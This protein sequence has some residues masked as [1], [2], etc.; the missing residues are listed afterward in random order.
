MLVEDSIIAMLF[1]IIG[2]ISFHLGKGMQ[3]HGI[4][5]LHYLKRKIFKNKSYPSINLTAKD[6]IIYLIGVFLS[7]SVAVWIMAANMFAPASYFTSMFGIGLIILLVYSVKVLGEPLKGKDVAGACVLII[8]T[9]LLGIDGIY[10][11][12]LSMSNIDI[13]TVSI[14]VVVFLVMAIIFIIST[15]NDKHH[16]IIGIGFG[17]LA[18]GSASLDPVFKG[19]GQNFGAKGGFVPSTPEGWVIFLISF[20]FATAAFTVV[21][22]AFM[23]KARASILVPVFS[24]VYISLP[25]LIQLLSLPGF[26][27]TAFTVSGLVFV[28]GGII[29][30][31]S[32]GKSEEEIFKS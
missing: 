26:S 29:M 30:M 23:K 3:K 2:T 17:L 31:Q 4:E 16:A 15:Y 13:K 5:V 27:V 22:F 10:R 12:E 20:I 32:V 1:G 19:A 21:Q 6:V 9:F 11:G 18:G 24:G 14:I 7:N 25:I 8:G 28:V